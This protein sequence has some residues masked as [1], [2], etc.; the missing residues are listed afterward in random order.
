MIIKGVILQDQRS[1]QKKVCG[2]QS[3]YYNL[4]GLELLFIQVIDQK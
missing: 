3:T 4:I 1:I 2:V